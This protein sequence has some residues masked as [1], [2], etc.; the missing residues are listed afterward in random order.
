MTAPISR[1]AGAIG[2]T[3]LVVI[4]TAACGSDPDPDA[5]SHSPTASASSDVVA[6][7]KK[8]ATKAYTKF[9]DA[10][11]KAGEIPD[12]NY[13]GLERYGSGEALEKVQGLI[14]GYRETDRV[15]HG[16]LKTHPKA[17]KATPADNPVAVSIT[18]C[19]DSTGWTSRD[20]DTGEDVDDGPNGTKLIKAIVELD[21]GVWKVDKFGMGEVGS[22]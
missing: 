16:S 17:T 19:A 4:S 20:K 9:W 10:V 12:P 18:D 15:M 3:A 5:G 11:G 2:M 14:A 22:C 13:S 21:E 7:T 6:Q 1:L 8:S